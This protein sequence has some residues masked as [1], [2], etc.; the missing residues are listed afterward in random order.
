MSH[1]HTLRILCQMSNDP[2]QDEAKRPSTRSGRP[3]FTEGRRWWSR[4]RLPW[5][6]LHFAFVASLAV[7]Y[8]RREPWG[9]DCVLKGHAGLTRGPDVCAAD[10]SPCGALIVTGGRDGTARIWDAHTGRQL[11]VLPGHEGPV[12][13]AWFTPEGRQAVTLS[14]GRAG[15]TW[16]T[17]DVQTGELIW[18]L[19]WV[20]HL[21]P[22]GTRILVSPSDE[23]GPKDVKWTLKAPLA[24]EKLAAFTAY[25]AEFT[26]DGHLIVS[27]SQD[28]MIRV[29][30]ARTGGLQRKFPCGTGSLEIQGVFAD[31]KRLVTSSKRFLFRIWDLETGELVAARQ[32]SKGRHELLCD[33]HDSAPIVTEDKT[34]GVILWDVSSGARICKIAIA[35][36]SAEPW[37]LFSFSPDASRLVMVEQ[38]WQGSSG[39][40]LAFVFDARTGQKLAGLDIEELRCATGLLWSP[41]EDRVLWVTSDATPLVYRRRFPELWWGHLYRPEVW[42]AFVLSLIWLWIVAMYLGAKLSAGASAA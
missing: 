9:L 30:D 6:V 16:R 4:L 22:D 5:L 2:P 11:H 17:W 40:D 12:E 15:A 10:F 19:P 27:A 14:F 29:R 8:V 25:A 34:H 1:R 36:P 41:V 23:D 42:V 13:L 31:G 26:L 37:P 39:W 7:V 35:G 38:F 24:D 20:G 21:S 3:E 18:A 28:G 33:S 32:A